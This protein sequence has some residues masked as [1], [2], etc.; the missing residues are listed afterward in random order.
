MP[1]HRINPTIIP[2]SIAT[3]RTSP[4][5]LTSGHNRDELFLLYSEGFEQGPGIHRDGIGEPWMEDRDDPRQ[6]ITHPCAQRRGT[7]LI[8]NDIAKSIEKE[9]I[10]GDGH[11]DD[12]TKQHWIQELDRTPNYFEEFAVRHPDYEIIGMQ[13]CGNLTM[14]TW[15]VGY[16]KSGFTAYRRDPSSGKRV[17]LGQPTARFLY[18][19]GEDFAHRTY[20]C[21]VKWKEADPLSLWRYTIEELNFNLLTKNVSRR[22][23]TAYEVITDRIEFAVFGQRIV[24]NGQLVDFGGIATQFGDIRHLYRLPNINP[25]RRFPRISESGLAVIQWKQRRMLFG[26]YRDNDVW[27]GEREL[28]DPDNIDL[29]THALTEPVILNTEFQNMGAD[30]GLIETAFADAGYRKMEE[31]EGSAY[32]PRARGFWRWYSPG[33][34]VQIFLQRNVY[35]YTMMGLDDEGNVI[36]SAA[37]GLAGRIGQT[38]EGMAQNMISSRCREVLLM[39]EGNDVFQWI[40]G[41]FTVA[42]LRGRVRAVLAAG[43]TG[44]GLRPE[45]RRFGGTRRKRKA[46]SRSAKAKEGRQT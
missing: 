46:S 21:L 8:D 17:D 36:V 38:L 22:R 42:P 10:T 25:S 43:R 16:L 41:G 20:T 30:P 28:T 27:F 13:G 11:I 34:L 45:E 7:W 6:K 40:A 39:D 37:G 23:G 14:N 9:A 44:R 26:H 5:K 32:P 18:L 19:H 3:F 4:S 15:F 33:R 12:N 35:A 24:Q 31:V 2:M 1:D 29:L